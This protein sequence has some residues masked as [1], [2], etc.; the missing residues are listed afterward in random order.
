MWNEVLVIENINLFD[1]GDVQPSNYPAIILFLFDEDKR[2]VRIGFALG[3]SLKILFFASQLD[4]IGIGLLKVP[5]K[6][7]DKAPAA[8]NLIA[9]L[10]SE[11]FDF[12]KLL[13]QF[14]HHFPPHLRWINFHKD[15]ASTAEVLMSAELLQL[16]APNLT[17][18]EVDKNDSIPMEILPD[19][20]KFRME[21][22]FAGVR[23][24]SKKSHFASGRFKIEL[25][26]GELKLS[27]GFSAKAFKTNS[28]FLDPFA[29]GYLLL[30][31]QFEFW[32]PIIIKHLDC[33][34]KVPSVLG[35]AL[36]RRPEKF[37]VKDKPKEMQRFLGKRNTSDDVECQQ[38]VDVFEI[39]ESEPLLGSSR[40]TK[41]KRALSH[42]KWPKFLQFSGD[43]DVASPLSLEREFTW[44]T[45]FYNSNRDPGM[46]NNSVHH[47]KVNLKR[48]F[49]S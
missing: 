15:G 36:I 12:R 21:V 31:D 45:K 30:P 22:T 47:L 39:E 2:K 26:M 20:R 17:V 41:V 4:L 16:P 37:F 49:I 9:N 10:L 29:S 33:S 28:N 19:M 1:I 8:S 5:I 42:Y 24:A 23:E 3:K 18:K 44:W 11:K 46:M 25:T 34:H 48:F 38:P 32:P 6:P 27:S 14:V 7:T 43:A 40:T 13:H 35:A